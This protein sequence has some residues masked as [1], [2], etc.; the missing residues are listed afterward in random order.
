[1]WAHAPWVGRYLPTSG[2][3]RELADY[4]LWCNAVEGNT[5]FYAT[6]TSETIARWRDLAPP[7]F[8]FAFKL[9]RLITHDRRLHRDSLRD[10]GAFLT[11]IAPLDDRIGP[12]QIQLPPS[13]GPD[14]LPVL[15]TFLGR[16]PL[17]FTWVVELRHPAFFDG[18]SAHRAVDSI[19]ERCRVGRVVLDTRAL[20]AGPAL[21]EAEI[22]ERRTKPA[23]PVVTDRMGTTPIV[24]V[25]GA[26]DPEQT[27]RGLE[28]WR[29]H[30]QRWIEEG[31]EPYV[32]VHQ[33][34]NIDS[35]GLARRFHDET[36]AAA[37]GIV[38]LPPA[39]E[40]SATGEIDGQTS[41]F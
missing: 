21:T 1:M 30:V 34:T 36:V 13:F 35:P 25:I 29:P 37:T 31:R 24:R 28:A 2:K 20:Y 22:D 14:G 3:G 23:L 4:A 38:P 32:F 6:P 11:A 17:E 18:S 39:P 9:P 16:L 40:I 26:D 7:S 15:R 8:R 5:T 27:Y 12:L 19:L 10:V 33:P 41:L